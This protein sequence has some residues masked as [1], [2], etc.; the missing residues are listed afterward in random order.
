MVRLLTALSVGVMMVTPVSGGLCYGH[1]KC[2]SLPYKENKA[3]LSGKLVR[4]Y[5]TLWHIMEYRGHF[6]FE[7]RWY[8]TLKYNKYLK[9]TI[10]NL[11]MH[12]P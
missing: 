9:V 6:P 1:T 5:C 3:Q 4:K 2:A 11:I 10:L 7:L 12:K 8:H